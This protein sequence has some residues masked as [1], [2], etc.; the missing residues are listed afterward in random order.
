MSYSANSKACIVE[1]VLFRMVLILLDMLTCQARIHSAVVASCLLLLL[2]LFAFSFLLSLLH[3][4]RCHLDGG[5][6]I[7]IHIDSDAHCCTLRDVM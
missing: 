1:V 4:E 7:T 6:E 3:V 5:E 2:F